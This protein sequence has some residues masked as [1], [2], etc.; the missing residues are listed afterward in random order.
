[1][2][3]VAYGGAWSD[4][5]NQFVPTISLVGQHA[6]GLAKA[7]ED[8]NAWSNMTDPDS[9]EVTFAFRKSGG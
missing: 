2:D 9:V 7:F 5:V 6:E 3:A 1:V 4:A 8:F